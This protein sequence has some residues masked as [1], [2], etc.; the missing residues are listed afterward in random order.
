MQSIKL[1]QPLR[2]KLAADPSLGDKDE[3]AVKDL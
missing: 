2:R 3:E 1:D